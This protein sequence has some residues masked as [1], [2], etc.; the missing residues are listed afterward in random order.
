MK[1]ITVGD[2]C[3]NLEA[4]THASYDVVCDDGGA[5]AMGCTISFGCDE[6]LIFYGD[7]ALQVWAILQSGSLK[8]M[9]PK[10]ESEAIAS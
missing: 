7:E 8:I 2:R 6:I 10:K 4:V 3:F 1:L 5:N 9:A